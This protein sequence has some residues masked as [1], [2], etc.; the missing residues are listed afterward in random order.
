MTGV[1]PALVALIAV[2]L[3]VRLPQRPAR[4]RQLHRHHRLDPGAAAALCGGL[5]GLLQFRRLPLLRPACRQ[6]RR[7]R[8]RRRRT[9]STTGVIFARSGGRDR[10]EHPHL[11]GRHALVQLARPDRRPGRRGRGQGGRLRPS[12][13]TG[14]SRPARPSSSR[15]CSASSW[16][17]SLV[18]LVSWICVRRTRRSRWIRPFACCNSSRPRSTRSAMAAMTRR[19]PWG[20]SPCC[21]MRMAERRDFPRPALGRALPARRRWRWAPSSAAGASCTPWGRRSPG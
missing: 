2:A 19:R 5:G 10:L 15:R 1:S 18:L 16:R 12:S 6:Y 20:S 11:A 8:H 7:R 4:R 9:S 13:G 17:S 3:A 21:S 14:S